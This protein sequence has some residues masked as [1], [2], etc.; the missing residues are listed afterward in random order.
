MC[1]SHA[2]NGTKPFNCLPR[3]ASLFRLF[4]STGFPGN[5]LM[6]HRRK[7]KGGEIGE[8]RGN[9][10]SPSFVA[11]TVSLAGGGNHIT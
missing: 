6:I 4:S 9:D 11:R 3:T 2:V 8:E 10:I 5:R 1:M 7:T